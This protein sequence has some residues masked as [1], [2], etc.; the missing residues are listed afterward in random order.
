MRSNRCAPENVMNFAALSLYRWG[1]SARLFFGV[2]VVL[3]LGSLV[4]WAG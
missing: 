3:V 2:S 4:A 1:I